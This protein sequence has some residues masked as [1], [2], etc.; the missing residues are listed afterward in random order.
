MGCLEKLSEKS[1]S[2]A[3]TADL[4]GIRRPK[5]TENTVS[6]ARKGC[7][8]DASETFRTVSCLTVALPEI[9]CSHL[10]RRLQEVLR[11]GEG[12]AAG[13]GKRTSGVAEPDFLSLRSS[14]TTWASSLLPPEFDR[15]L[16][17]Q[18]R[19][20]NRR[21][22]RRIHPRRHAAFTGHRPVGCRRGARRPALLRRGA[23]R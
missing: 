4:A 13:V 18:E 21:S 3:P 15:H 6:V 17:A 5:W 7:V 14:P 2:N 16:R 10:A 9:G 22:G 12:Y 20:A 1:K 8:A 23:L 19:L 11:R